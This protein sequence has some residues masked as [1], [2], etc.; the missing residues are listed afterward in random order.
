M[1]ENLRANMTKNVLFQ[2]TRTGTDWIND[3]H[4]YKL[5]QELK[6]NVEHNLGDFYVNKFRGEWILLRR[7]KL[8]FAQRTTT[9]IERTSSGRIIHLRFFLEGKF[10][11][12]ISFWDFG[13]GM[14]QLGEKDG[15]PETLH[16][17][18]FAK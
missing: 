1:S 9:V 8:T 4:E 13:T 16:Q 11:P 3:T 5:Y 6:I 18:G 12:K 17:V 2:K 7:L 15:K 10:A 14:G